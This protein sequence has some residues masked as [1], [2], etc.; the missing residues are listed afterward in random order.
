MNQKKKQERKMPIKFKPT[1]LTVDRSTGK[2]SI[3][4]FYMRSTPL[5]IRLLRK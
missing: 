1:Q 4:N 5:A 3:Q 2:K